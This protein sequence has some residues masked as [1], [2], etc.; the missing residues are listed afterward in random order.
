MMAKNGN[1]VKREQ[2]Q[3]VVRIPVADDLEATKMRAVCFSSIAIPRVARAFLPGIP[4]ST[5]LYRRLRHSS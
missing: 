3:S 5:A 2:I 4:A 1:E